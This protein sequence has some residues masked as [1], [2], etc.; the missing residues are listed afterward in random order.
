LAT[1]PTGTTIEELTAANTRKF[2][3]SAP[4]PQTIEVDARAK[5]EV[6]R[7][8]SVPEKYRTFETSGLEIL[9]PER[10]RPCDLRLD[11]GRGLTKRSVGN[12]P[13]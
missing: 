13:S 9:V 1:V 11:S 3:L 8:T 4:K 7:A 5:V 10:P 6:R 12:A 2:L